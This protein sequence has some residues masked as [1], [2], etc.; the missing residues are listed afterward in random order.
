MFDVSDGVGL[1]EKAGVSEEAMNIAYKFLALLKDSD[2]C[3]FLQEAENMSNQDPA[4][5]ALI[6]YQVKLVLATR[7][8]LLRGEGV[9]SVG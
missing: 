3:L 4:K 2:L 1:R 8:G 7:L 5:K 6:I 9:P